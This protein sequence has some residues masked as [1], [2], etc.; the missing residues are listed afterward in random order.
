MSHRSCAKSEASRW[1]TIAQVVAHICEADGCDQ[2]D[3]RPE[4][5]KALAVGALGLLRWK[6]AGSQ[7]GM[8]PSPDPRWFDAEIDWLAGTVR[9]DWGDAGPRHRVLLIP[10]LGL[11]ERWPEMHPQAG[12]DDPDRYEAQQTRL[13]RRDRE[14]REAS[15]AAWNCAWDAERAKPIGQRQWFSSGELADEMARHPQTLA[16]DA[17][18]AARIREKLVEW[19]R[20]R[21]FDLGAGEVTTLSGSPPSF[22]PL[23]PIPPGNILV[24]GDGLMLRRD[25]ARRFVASHRKVPNAAS[26]LKQW[27]ADDPQQQDL[28]KLRLD[29]ERRVADFRERCRVPPLQTTKDGEQGDREWAAANGVPRDDIEAWR[30]ELLGEKAP[31]RGR[32]R[33]RQENNSTADLS[34]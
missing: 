34:K 4:L 10:C 32:P 18:L 16:I 5:R 20:N 11:R 7:P 31:G 33:N 19:I 14:Q 25:A 2:D 3:A 27:F 30:R 9:D 12:W 1:R 29:Y 23:P 6:D 15:D 24:G 26:M 22:V 17:G 21:R 13:M 8:P 28:R